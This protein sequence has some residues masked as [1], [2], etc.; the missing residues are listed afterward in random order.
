MKYPLTEII[1][2]RPIPC[3]YNF[4]SKR[5]GLLSV[6]PSSIRMDTRGSNISAERGGVIHQWSIEGVTKFPNPILS[7]AIMGGLAAWFPSFGRRLNQR[8]GR[9]RRAP[10]VDGKARSM[11]A[12]AGEGS[13]L[14]A[15]GATCSAART[16]YIYIQPPK[17][18][19]LRHVKHSA[20]SAINNKSNHRG[21]FLR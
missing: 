1:T 17:I 20:A 13:L 15:R 2:Q 5:L 6:C 10:I 12:R 14:D 7:I 21:I 18:K 4:C 19:S 11:D 8:A 16:V 3:W 9:A